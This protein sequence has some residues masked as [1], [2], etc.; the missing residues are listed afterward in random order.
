M[1]ELTIRSAEPEDAESIANLLGELG[2]PNTSEFAKEKILAI[3]ESEDDTLLVAETEGLIIGTTHLHI[4]E[5]VHERG[6]LA[7][8]MALIVTSKHQGHGVGKRLIATAE[9]M[10]QNR[11]CSK[12][13]VTSAIHRESA[14]RFYEGLNY[15]EQRR[16]FVKQLAD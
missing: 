6:K 12:I 13:E 3:A 16:R 11:G 14:R 15:A 5:M 2:Y 8:I 9:S 10:A 1:A 7:R 4:A